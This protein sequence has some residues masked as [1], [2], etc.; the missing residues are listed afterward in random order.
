MSS[1]DTRRIIEQEAITQLASTDGR[2]VIAEDYVQTLWTL[3]DQH[4]ER[5]VSTIPNAGLGLFTRV[6]VA[7]GSVLTWYDGAV[8][9]KTEYDRRKAEDATVVDYA[10]DLGL[11][12]YVVLG[13]HV[14]AT[15]A[16]TSSGGSRSSSSSSRDDDDDDDIVR[17]APHDLERVFTG[18]GAAQFCNTTLAEWATERNATFLNVT[19]HRWL[20]FDG[21]NAPL[22][23]DL[24]DTLI[25]RY[26]RGQGRLRLLVTLRDV[27]AGEE[28]LVY[29]GRS[30]V[31]THLL[32]SAPSAAKRFRSWRY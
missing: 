28:L 26:P 21:P 1:V 18:R 19:D 22:D 6:P 12:S 27:A 23:F 30:Y 10:L 17:V 3:G 4:L 29:Y 13:D 11:H 24:R 25:R 8:I 9:S 2:P 31:E 15:D 5:R 16:D 32:P 7:A 20:A 14:Y